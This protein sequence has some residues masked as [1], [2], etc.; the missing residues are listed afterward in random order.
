MHARCQVGI[1]AV[2]PVCVGGETL[3]DC[4]PDS[5]IVSRI[6]DVRIGFSQSDQRV[7][8]SRVR[9][10]SMVVVCYILTRWAIIYVVQKTTANRSTFRCTPVRYAS[11]SVYDVLTLSFKHDT[12]VSGRFRN[13][14][15]FM[16]NNG[17]NSV[18]V[19]LALCKALGP[20]RGEIDSVRMKNKSLV[21]KVLSYDLTQVQA[22]SGG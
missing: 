12:T 6:S 19:Y 22:W 2:E 14:V 1:V 5:Q 11:R 15:V 13:G 4:D 8:A 3:G 7:K 21:G 18:K 17:C 9:L 10:Q 20:R 16:R